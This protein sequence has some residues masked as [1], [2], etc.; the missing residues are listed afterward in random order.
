MSVNLS[1]HAY[2]DSEKMYRFM[3]DLSDEEVCLLL[4]AGKENEEK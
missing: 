2:S 3:G 4:S 1:G